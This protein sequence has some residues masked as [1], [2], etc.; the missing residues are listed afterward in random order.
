MTQSPWRAAG[1]AVL[2]SASAA[3]QPPPIAPETALRHRGAA[4]AYL[5][6]G[7]VELAALEIE[8]LEAALHGE[9]RRL[10]ER[11]RAELESGDLGAASASLARLRAHLA[12]G[13]RAAGVRI[14][15]DCIE[16]A[17]A[18]LGA[19]EPGRDPRPDL[20][21]PDRRR[22]L[23]ERADAARAALA[24]CDREA[25]PETAGQPDFRRLVDG[26][27]A[28]LARIPAA[29]ERGDG[30]VLH[31]LLIELRSFERLLVQRFG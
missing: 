4:A 2:L 16:E 7:N 28:S 15:A 30:D 13:R 10:A 12:D 3:A 25:P 17:E 29:I 14:L 9:A 5:R 8:A 6:T 31:R 21:R 26:A 18:R 1:L 23:A 11:A 20:S 24:L 22:A 19:I 27:A